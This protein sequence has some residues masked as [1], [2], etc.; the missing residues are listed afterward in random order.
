MFFIK[1][2]LNYNI[3]ILISLLI[4]SLY[5]HM[6]NETTMRDAITVKMEALRLKAPAVHSHV[7]ENPPSLN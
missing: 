1:I 7:P 3:L 4:K 2:K 6:I 5:G